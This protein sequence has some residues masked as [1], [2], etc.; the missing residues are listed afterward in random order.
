MNSK[1]ISCMLGMALGMTLSTGAQAGFGD[2]LQKV[3]QA[4]GSSWNQGGQSSG[5]GDVNGINVDRAP[6]VPASY[7]PRVAANKYPSLMPMTAAR[8]S[9]CPTT[10]EM[11][12]REA[13]CLS[14]A[15][16]GYYSWGGQVGA[17]VTCA[18]YLFPDGRVEVEAVAE[19]KGKRDG[20]GT[21]T[22]IRG[23][24]NLNSSPVRFNRF[25]QDGFDLSTSPQGSINFFKLSANSFGNEMRGQ[26]SVSSGS[27]EAECTVPLN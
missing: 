16:L 19:G 20:S 22:T 2:L 8:L 7:Q 25:A 14:G 24:F 17:P 26:F 27:R 9:R 6:R 15:Y 4:T 3:Q 12:A 23:S 1:Y 10:G 21:G 5:S 13:K 18:A 11:G